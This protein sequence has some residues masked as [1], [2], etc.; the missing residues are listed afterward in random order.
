[1]TREEVALGGRGWRPRG[2]LVGLC[3]WLPQDVAEPLPG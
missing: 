1:M 2:R 3:Q